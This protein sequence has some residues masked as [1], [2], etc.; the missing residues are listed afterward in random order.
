MSTLALARPCSSANSIETATTQ[1]QDPFLVL[2][3]T[4]RSHARYAFRRLPEEAKQEAIQE[5][6]ATSL[7]AYRRLAEEGREPNATATTLARYAVAHYRVGRRVANRMN[8]S[9]VTSKYCQ[10]RTGVQVQSLHRYDVR[11]GE[12]QEIIVE[13]RN[14]TAADIAATRIDFSAWLESL[15][16][17]MRALAQ[18]LATGETTETVAR[19]FRVSAGRI[20]QI[21]RKLMET[22]DA[23]QADRVA[24]PDLVAA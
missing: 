15:S 8:I 1:A 13:D 2:L 21:R 4:I 9:D 20:S 12:W 17:R 3:P 22:W 6:V 5:V 10:Y 14:A 23:F 11:D 18:T 24:E 19:M 16:P 7:A